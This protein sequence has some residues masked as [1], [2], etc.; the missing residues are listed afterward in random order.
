MKKLVF[1]LVVVAVAYVGWRVFR[2]DA[3]QADG[4]RGHALFYGRAWIDHIPASPN[5]KF[6]VFGTSAGAPFGWFAQR[7]KW[8]GEWEQFRYE[9]R[10]DG[11]VE[12]LLPSSNQR[13]RLAYRAW[14]C[15][16]QKGLHYCLELTGPK[17]TTKY[18]SRRG[19]EKRDLE[20]RDALD[21]ELDALAA[22]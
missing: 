10:G 6:N 21:A 19:W 15:N 5:D 4:G 13:I 7:T 14:E 11:E 22:R 2:G 17:G 9:P 16:E 3:E 12:L 18:Y 20:G 8:K 1:T